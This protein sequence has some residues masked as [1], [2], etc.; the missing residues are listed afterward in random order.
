MYT[1]INTKH[2][3]QQVSTYLRLSKHKGGVNKGTIAMGLDLIMNNNIFQFGDTYWKQIDGTAMGTPPAPM[4]ATLYFAPHEEATTKKYSEILLYKR[5]IDD[6][7]GIWVP[8]PAN[9]DLERWN[10]FQQD[11]NTYGKIRWEFTERSREAIFL[12]LKITIQSNQ[13]ISTIIYEKPLN[14]YLYLPP[15][16]THLQGVLKGLVYGSITRIFRLTSDKDIC[17]KNI[18]DLFRRLLA[19]GFQTNQLLPIFADAQKRLTSPREKLLEDPD[20][21]RIFFHLPFHPMDPPSNVIQKLFRDEL[22]SP[23]NCTPLPDI[24]NHLKAKLRTNRLIVAYHRP[25]NLGNL[26]SPRIINA[27]KGPPV[28]AY[29]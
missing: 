20:E 26:M 19:R 9:N 6:V 22:L 18:K 27:E 10:A 23:P 28:S 13:R 1:N 16:S 11:M 3:L 25:P 5:Y 24:P 7:I 8:D 12:D 21:K 14:L 4:Y 15:H 17:Q 2:A 29:L